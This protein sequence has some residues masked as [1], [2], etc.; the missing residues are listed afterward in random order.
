MIY[1]YLIGVFI[2]GWILGYATCGLLVTASATWVRTDE[3][4]TQ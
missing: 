1:L 3:I 2:F 4:E